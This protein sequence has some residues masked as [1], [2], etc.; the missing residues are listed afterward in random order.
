MV[1]VTMPFD[2]APLAW[3]RTPVSWLWLLMAAEI[4]SALAALLL[5][6]GTMLLLV[7]SAE[8]EG[9]IATPL[10]TRS[11]SFRAFDKAGWFAV[12][13]TD[14]TVP[15][16]DEALVVS[17]KAVPGLEAVNKTSPT[18][19]PAVAVTPKVVL[20]LMAVTKASRCPCAVVG[21]AVEL[22]AVPLIVSV[23]VSVL[24]RVPPMVTAFTC[25]AETSTR[26]RGAVL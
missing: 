19:R 24:A 23:K 3:A 12:T 21:P 18:A 11:S 6:K 16:V 26:S 15:A 7:S 2:T 5:L 22:K 4:A 13:A 8:V 20:A 10:I 9:R 25:A 17:V 1:W 14:V